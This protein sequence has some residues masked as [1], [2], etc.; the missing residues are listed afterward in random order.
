MA[1]AIEFNSI[2]AFLRGAATVKPYGH[3][4]PFVVESRCS[5]DF[6]NVD[7]L[8]AATRTLMFL[9]HGVC[10]Y[11]WDLLCICFC[12]DHSREAAN[13]RNVTATTWWCGGRWKWT[14]KNREKKYSLFFPVQSW[15]SLISLYE[16]S[17]RHNGFDGHDSSFAAIT[18]LFL[19]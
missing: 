8:H 1:L 6:G 17:R 19:Y 13:N 5:I 12:V 14:R 18:P 15:L 9:L 11:F 4:D 10:R 2:V 16:L 7:R 3:G